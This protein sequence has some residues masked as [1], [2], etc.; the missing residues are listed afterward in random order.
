MSERLRDLWPSLYTAVQKQ[1]VD[2][3]REDPAWMDDLSPS[4]RDELR[5]EAA[6]ELEMMEQEA[7]RRSDDGHPEH[8][9]DVSVEYQPDKQNGEFRRVVRSNDEVSPE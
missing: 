6:K 2:P 9:D 1:I 4:E 8:G 3:N 5:R 7:R